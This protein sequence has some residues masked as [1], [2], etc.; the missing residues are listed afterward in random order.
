MANSHHNRFV[1]RATDAINNVFS[2]TSVTK[3]QTKRSLTDLRNEINELLEQL[4]NV[5]QDES[6]FDDEG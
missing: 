4:G 6:D 3:S 1:E 5:G 2:D